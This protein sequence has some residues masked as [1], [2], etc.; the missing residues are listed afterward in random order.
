MW[1]E[2]TNI[3]GNKEFVNMGAAIRF[4]SERNGN[5]FVCFGLNDSQ[6]LLFQETTEAI[7]AKLGI[8]IANKEKN[9]LNKA[10]KRF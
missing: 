4:G 5:T 2:L 6:Y 10:I 8:N 7:A 3:V 9:M 1:I